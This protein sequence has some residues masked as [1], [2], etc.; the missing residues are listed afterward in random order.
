MCSSD[1]EDFESLCGHGQSPAPFS[2]A[3]EAEGLSRAMVL[4]VWPLDQV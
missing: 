2:I 4:Q 3:L 1:L